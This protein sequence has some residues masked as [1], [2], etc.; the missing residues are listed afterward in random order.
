MSTPTRHESPRR[1]LS[2]QQAGTVDRL[3]EAALEVLREKGTTGLTVREVAKRA[4]VAA[5]TA[6]T[7]FS[8]K[9]HVVVEVFWRRLHSLPEVDLEGEGDAADR[10]VI[11]LRQVA[12]LVADEPE[13]ASATTASLLGADPEVEHLRIEVGVEIRRRLMAALAGNGGTE[14]VDE[15]VLE[16][17]ESV[18]SGALLRAGLGYSTYEQMAD[19][20]E[21]AARTI[22]R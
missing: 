10:V 8:S 20:V 14:A 13:L 6:Y 12:L 15:R 5:A 19:S 2:D 4:R 7:Y 9:D 3:T 21:F 17:L 11:V 22:L 16:A 1:R 18:Y